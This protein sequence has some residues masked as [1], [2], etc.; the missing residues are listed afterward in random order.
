MADHV[1]KAWRALTVPTFKMRIAQTFVVVL[2]LVSSLV[3][4]GAIVLYRSS[5]A[6]RNTQDGAAIGRAAGA[7]SRA[8]SSFDSA[9]LEEVRG[10]QVDAETATGI[11]VNHLR[12]AEAE[13]K[14]VD[15]AGAQGLARETAGLGASIKSVATAAQADAARALSVKAEALS[16]SLLKSAVEEGRGLVNFG[17][18]A[19]V[20]ILIVTCIAGIV[21]MWV[22]YRGLSGIV[23]K[24]IVEVRAIASGKGDLTAR[25]TV[26]T[27][28][29]MGDLADS[30][31][32]MV[33]S[34]RESMID[35]RTIAVQLSDSAD[36]L[37]GSIEGM[38]SSIEEVTAAAEQISTGSEDQARKVED[39][40]HAMAG[41]SRTIEG[42]A[43]KGQVSA[44]QSELTAEL[45]RHGGEASVEAT[46]VMN[47]IYVSVKNSE[48]LMEGLGERFTQIGIIIDVITD[49]A[50]Q[51]NLLA[52]NAA[53]EAAR[54]GEHGKGFAVV[55][56]EVRK[57]AENSKR[58][59]EQISHL[60][61]E[62][63]SETSRVSVS[64]TQSTGCVDI[65]Q[66]VAHKT[67]EALEGITNS[68]QTAA[69]AAGE[70]SMAIQSI[71]ENT[72][73]VFG[74]INDIAAIA[75][76]TA[77]STEEV[78]ATINEQ[79][80]STEDVAEQSLALARLAA[81]LHELTRGF[82]V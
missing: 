10:R 30:I 15:T 2:C 13:L 12:S 17:V 22:A 11:G 56:G 55:A 31:N 27:K 44:R 57:L 39:T 59:A 71:A 62:I 50:D 75:Q 67:G 14:K 82:K 74:A 26:P 16:Q 36:S 33:G 35:I 32:D 3:I 49:I 28:D 6:R 80:V 18:I 9:T 1:R 29:V 46:R 19:Y 41:V 68:S 4:V 63:M 78:A 34:L 45:A 51:T 81:Q 7:C 69:H 38:S 48:V 53:I 37:A 52:L 43:D 25:V 47:E 72:D 77:A 58:S 42:I 8:A 79:R 5:N 24:V 65:G 76:E 61:R 70:I 66:E 60:I 23:K 20:I 73:R 21:T 54:A 64:M 40:S